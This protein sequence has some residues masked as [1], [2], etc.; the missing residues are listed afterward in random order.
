MSKKSDMI[1]FDN[2]VQC[3]DCA[4]RAAKILERVLEN[5]RSGHE[6]AKVLMKSMR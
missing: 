2:F 6:S 1:Y 3:A 4:V 5:F